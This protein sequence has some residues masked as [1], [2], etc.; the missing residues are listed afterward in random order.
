MQ[1]AADLGCDSYFTL[2]TTAQSR[3][4]FIGRLRFES[5]KEIKYADLRDDRGEPYI[6]DDG[7][8]VSATTAFKRL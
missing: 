8:H 1:V 5:F 2:L 6:R 7:G 4:L 3:A